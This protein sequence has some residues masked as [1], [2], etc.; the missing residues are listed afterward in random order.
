M[1]RQRRL[2]VRVHLKQRLSPSIAMVSPL[3]SPPLWG[4]DPDHSYQRGEQLPLPDRFCGD[5]GLVQFWRGGYEIVLNRFCVG[6][7]PQC[8]GH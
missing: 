3:E 4:L 1:K 6:K 2:S 8:I 7:G 5:I